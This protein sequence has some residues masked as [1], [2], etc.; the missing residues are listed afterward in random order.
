M[1]FRKILSLFL[2]VILALSVIAA[3]PLTASAQEAGLAQTALGIHPL[4]YHNLRDTL[5][6]TTYMAAVDSGYMRL[7]YNASDEQIVIEY[8]SESFDILS[9]RTLELELP[10]WGGFYEGSD[11]YYLV[12]GQYN[13]DCVDDTEVLRV[14]KYSKDWERLGSGSIL[15]KDGWEYEI[16]YPFN[17]GCVNMTEVEGQLYIVTA[18]EGYVDP[19]YGQG[20]QGMMLIRVD[21]ETMNSEIIY[22]DFWHSFSQYIDTVDNKLYVLEESEG[23]QFTALTR[24]DPKLDCGY[25]GVHPTIP[26]L[27][28][29]GQRVSAWSV[30]T[31]ASVDDI[32][33]NADSI[34]GVGISIDQTQYENYESDKTPYNIYLTV[35]PV[36]DFTEEASSLIWLTEYEELRDIRNIKLRRV[37]DDRFIVLWTESEHYSIYDYQSVDDNMPA[38]KNDTLSKYSMHY[39]FI[40]SQ[41]NRISDEYTAEATTSQCEPIVKGNK[42]V[43]YSSDGSCVDFYSVDSVTGELEKKVYRTSGEN[44]TWEYRNGSLIYSGEG[45]ITNPTELY[46][47]SDITE[48]IFSAGIT[49]IP[50]ISVGNCAALKKI[51]F[52]GDIQTLDQIDVTYHEPIGDGWYYIRRRN[53]DDIYI[54]GDIHELN[55]ESFSYCYNTTFHCYEGSDFD[56]YAAQNNLKVEYLTPPEGHKVSGSITSFIDDSEVSVSLITKPSD[57]QSGYTPGISL[58]DKVYGRKAGYSFDDIPAGSYTLTVTK[59]DHEVGEY[60]VEVGD[61]DV[62]LDVT[63]CPIKGLL[64]DVDANGEVEITDATFIQRSLTWV[65]VPYPERMIKRFGDV[66]GDTELSII[67]ATFIQRYNV[68][69]RTPYPIGEPI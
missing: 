13:A 32:A 36:S 41:G 58:K 17:H 48:I 37:G 6:K 55:D 30:P 60:T 33:V 44:T 28:Y 66:D 43:F 21:E 52:E 9:R 8:Y 53:I 39:V 65:P 11:A 12:E 25:F 15:A 7:F 18:R 14:I 22:G 27:K 63:I 47:N 38:D 26:L 2:S 68:N 24:F 31:Y 40:D 1:K 57:E 3:A 34:L 51:I 5:I 19:Q 20:H 29:G 10:V 45:A 67:D 16:R 61:S 23:S 64:G 50:Y 35:T 54:Y 69:M 56:A 62:S 42:I 49:D 59:Q 46:E 4:P